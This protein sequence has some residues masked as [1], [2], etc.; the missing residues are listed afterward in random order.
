MNLTPEQSTRLAELVRLNETYQS[1]WKKHATFDRKGGSSAT[2]EAVVKIKA[3]C[4]F[5]MTNDMRS[6]IEVLE[7][8][9]DEPSPVFA[10]PSLDRKSVVTFAD[11]KLAD[12]YYI[13]KPFE[14]GF[15]GSYRQTFRGHAINGRSYHGTIYGTYLRMRIEQVKAAKSKP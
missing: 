12:I 8:I 3:E 13:S 7:F 1:A 2:A 6:E 5:D 10:Y 4:G 9:R 11:H 15:Q 14:G